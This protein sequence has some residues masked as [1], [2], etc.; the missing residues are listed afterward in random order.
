MNAMGCMQSV[1]ERA[2]C[3]HCTKPRPRAAL[4]VDLWLTSDQAAKY[5]NQQPP[6]LTVRKVWII[7][8]HGKTSVACA[9]QIKLANETWL[10]PLMHASELGDASMS[11]CGSDAP[12]SIALEGPR[13]SP[14]HRHISNSNVKGTVWPNNK[15]SIA[16]LSG[17]IAT[18]RSSNVILMN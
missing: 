15:S 8:A 18:R 17:P 4:G 11:W 3:C 9:D 13:F 7:K 1:A 14:T 6:E 16:N 12:L 10:L 5:M 2:I